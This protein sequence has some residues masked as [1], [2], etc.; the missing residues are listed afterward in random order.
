M[1]SQVFLPQKTETG[2]ERKRRMEAYGGEGLCTVFLMVMY[3]GCMQTS[4]LIKSN[5]SKMCSFLT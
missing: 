2:K 3:H 5:A 4:K 1:S